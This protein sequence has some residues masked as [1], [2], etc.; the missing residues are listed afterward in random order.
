MSLSKNRI[1]YFF[2]GTLFA[3]F[4][5]SKKLVP[6]CREGNNLIFISG[7]GTRPIVLGQNHNLVEALDSAVG[8][9]DG[10]ASSGL[11]QNGGWRAMKRG[12]ATY[13]GD[14][15]AYECL[16]IATAKINLAS[17]K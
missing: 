9:V 12:T 14:R 13:Q 11:F 4:F 1:S 6:L 15:L 10:V 7:P 16:A 3:R 2:H 8:L 5:C 17:G